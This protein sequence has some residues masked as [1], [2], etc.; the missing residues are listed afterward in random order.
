MK[1]KSPV[2]DLAE[3]FNR[4]LERLMPL[5][6]PLGV[7]MGFALPAV[8][9]A[10][11]PFIPWLFGVMTLSGALKLK[12]REFARSL[13][14]PLPILLSFISAHVILP[15]LSFLIPS[16]VFPGK[17]EI[18]AGYLLLSAAPT[19]VSSFIWVSIYGGDRAL[20][21]AIILIDTILAPFV[22]P[23]TMSV[24]MGT[25]VVLDMTGIAVSLILMVLLPTVFG[26]T[27]NEASRSRAPAVLGPVLN[28]F[29]KLC[30]ILVIAANSAAVAP[31][32]HVS[33]PGLWLIGGVCI[34]LSILGYLLS[35]F[36]GT[37]SRLGE[38]SRVT[39]F[40]N[41]GLRN[42]SAASTIAIEFFPAAAALP[43]LLG[44]VVQQ[45][46]AA[47]M[48]R[49]MCPSGPRTLPAGKA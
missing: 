26:I 13:K 11:R 27:L 20:C 24:L 40:F 30:L 6:T 44:I 17:T 38:A 2:L 29:A 9:L 14:T 31:E 47:L 39:V 21:L 8:F 45:T 33:D 23:A 5:L 22:V 46:M 41:V 25:R 16:L 28:P 34:L 18:I 1:K 4:R 19:A 36:T 42:I 12:A 48:S 49:I 3:I 15:L 43:C 7:V 32:L 10:F 35:R 37:V